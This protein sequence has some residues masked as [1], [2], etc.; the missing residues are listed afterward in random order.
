V[1]WQYKDYK[2]KEAISVSYYTTPF[3]RLPEE[4]DALVDR[5]L[6]GLERGEAA[7]TELGRLRQVILATYGK[8]PEDQGAKAFV[9]QQLW[10]EPRKDFAFSRLRADQEAVLKKIDTRITAAGTK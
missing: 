4:V 5:F 3:P 9:S 6:K 10:Y 1:R 8:E 2:P 7:A